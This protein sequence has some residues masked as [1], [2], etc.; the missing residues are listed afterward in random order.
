MVGPAG[1]RTADAADDVGLLADHAVAVEAG[2][3]AWVGPDQECPDAAQ[4]VDARGALVTPGFVDPHTHLVYAGDRAFELALKLAGRPYLDILAAGGGIAHTVDATRAATQG[5][6]VREASSRLRRMMANGTTSLEAKSGYGLETATEL[7][8]IDA[9][10]ATATDTGVT[11]VH[12]FLGAHAVPGEYAGRPDAYVDVVV[13]EMLPAVQEQGLATFCDVF[14]EKDVFTVEHGRTILEA[15]RRHSLAP[16]LHADEIVNT[17]GAQ[18]AAEVHAAS[19]D[20]LLRVS[21]EGIQA[22]AAAGTIAT[23]LPT[24]PLTLFSPEWAPAKAMLDAGVPIALATDH[25]P[26][27]PATDMNLVAQ[28]ACFTMRLTPGQALTGAT[29][30]AA[31][32]LG[33]QDEVGSIEVGKR[34]D[35]VVHDVPDLAHWVYE[36]GRRTVKHVVMGGAQLR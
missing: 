7:K 17:G 2:R 20:H 11:M 31:C 30:N 34:A 6:L 18:L 28:L 22:M 23:L 33:I 32:S 21:P 26:N 1:P 16:R 12:T 3:I 13:D 24:V 29:W 8:Q 14:V 5:G 4:T 15:A 10:A 36:P 27:N 19:A 25:N 9:A 35:L